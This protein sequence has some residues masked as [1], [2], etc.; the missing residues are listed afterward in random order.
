MDNTISI[1]I[2]IIAALSSSIITG[3]ITIAIS[4]LNKKAELEKIKTQSM[5]NAGV[6]FWKTHVEIAKIK[7]ATTIPPMSS[8]VLH[9]HKVSEIMFD[10][11]TTKYNLNSRLSEATDLMIE[12]DKFWEEQT[13]ARSKT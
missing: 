7:G 1:W 8:Y 10:P 13:A 6:E 5:I 12:M 4:S 2:P 9:M 3:L 11:T